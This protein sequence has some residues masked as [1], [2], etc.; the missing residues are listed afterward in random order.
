MRN[1]ILYKSGEQSWI[2]WI[3]KRIKNNLN[4]LAIAEGEV[5]I[6]KSWGL[7]RIA[8]DIDNSFEPRQV[9]FNFKE[10]MDILN[11]DWFNE[12]EW[13]IIIFDEAQ[14]SISNRSWQSLTNKLMNYLLSTFRH[15]NIIL[16]FT[17]PYTDFLDSQTLKLIH[18]KFEVRGH[19]SKTEKTRIRPKLLQYNS[20]LKKFYEHSLFVLRDGKM[21]KLV[22]WFVNKP[23]QHLIIPYE[24]AKIRFTTQLNKDITQELENLEANKNKSVGKGELNPDSMQPEIWRI[25][26]EGYRTQQEIADKL[27]KIKDRIVKQGEVSR[28]VISMSKRG[29]DIRQY[30][31]K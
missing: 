31:L 8:Y 21:H 9:A 17:S 3:K 20:K 28:D 27:S 30:K 5:G 26:Q 2:A 12:K 19:N 15:R 4:F 14:T 29:Y 7:I 6:G 1:I 25:A 23:P 11:S 16:L 13:K 24:E 22:Y 18:C 10:V